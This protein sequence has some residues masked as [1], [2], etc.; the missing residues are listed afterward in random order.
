[1]ATCGEQGKIGIL[2]R[3]RETVGID[4][5]VRP[6]PVIGPRDARMEFELSGVQLEQVGITHAGERAPIC[7]LRRPCGRKVGPDNRIA[8]LGVWPKEGVRIV[9]PTSRDPLQIRFNRVTGIDDRTL[10]GRFRGGRLW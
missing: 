8:V 1:M 2:Q 5:L 3:R 9:V 6:P 10:R 4:A 7:K